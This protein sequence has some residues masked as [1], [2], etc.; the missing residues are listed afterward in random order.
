MDVAIPSYLTSHHPLQERQSVRA[1]QQYA[2]GRTIRQCI[3]Q[4]AHNEE[5]V[6]VSS[7]KYKFGFK[8]ILDNVVMDYN[9]KT[10]F[11]N[12]LKIELL[13]LEIKT[14]NIEIEKLKLQQSFNLNRIVLGKFSKSDNQIKPQSNTLK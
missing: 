6:Q 2:A 10:L 13:E 9:T 7:S 4:A 11:I 14:I 12:D 5:G 8:G 1:A 3:E